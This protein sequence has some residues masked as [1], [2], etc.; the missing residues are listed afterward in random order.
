MFLGAFAVL[1]VV[2]DG[3]VRAE[4]FLFDRE[5]FGVIRVAVTGDAIVVMVELFMVVSAVSAGVVVAD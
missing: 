1:V 3:L 5:L 2:V 4:A